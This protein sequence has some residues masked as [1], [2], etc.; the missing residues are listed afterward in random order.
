MRL[1]EVT[2]FIYNL[3]VHDFLFSRWSFRVAVLLL[4]Q[5]F[6]LLFKDAETYKVVP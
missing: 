6:L 2:E 4:N 1:N 3:S 5:V